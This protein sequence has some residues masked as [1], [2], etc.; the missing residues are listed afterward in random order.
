MTLT[1]AG[2]VPIHD[3]DNRIWELNPPMELTVML[4]ELLPPCA[5][6]IVEDDD[7]SEKSGNAAVDVVLFVVVEL[8]VWL[9]NV[10]VAEAVAPLG[11]AIAVT[12]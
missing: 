8:V 11:L 5:S 4:A 6:V 1:L 9:V 12:V 7:V 10:K 2:G 3:A